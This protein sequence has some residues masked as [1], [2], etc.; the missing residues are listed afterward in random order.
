MTK[1]KQISAQ[2]L[3]ID[4]SS[5]Q[6]S[7]Y[8][9]WFLACLLFGKPIQQEVAKRTYGEFVKE[10]L[11]TPDAIL[12]AGWDKLVE[13]LD[14]GH[15]VRYDF[16][17]ATKL[18]DISKTLKDNYGT[19]TNLV[20]QSP[21]AK[22]LSARLQQFK[23]IGPK[24]AEIF[25]RDLAPVVYGNRKG[26]TDDHHYTVKVQRFDGFGMWHSSSAFKDVQRAIYL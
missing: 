18:L 8:F 12:H 20:R 2:D 10:K 5:K 9:H 19:L 21:S 13:V 11:T 26:E 1:Q 17:T 23:G 4:L 24:T 25:L 15:Y 7:A 22:D 16:S 14:H 3:G 6:E